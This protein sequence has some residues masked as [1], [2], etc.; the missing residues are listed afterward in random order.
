MIT[1]PKMFLAAIL[2]QGSIGSC[3]KRKIP[4]PANKPVVKPPPGPMPRKNQFP[5]AVLCQGPIGSCSKRKIPPP[6]NKPVVK[7]PSGPMPQKKG[8]M[9]RSAV[10]PVKT[11]PSQDDTNA[12]QEEE[13]IMETGSDTPRAPSDSF[14]SP[15]G[16]KPDSFMFEAL[17]EVDEWAK[18]RKEAPK[19]SKPVKRVAPKE[20]V[21]E[22]FSL[23]ARC[24]IARAA[25]REEAANGVTLGNVRLDLVRAIGSLADLGSDDFWKATKNQVSWEKVQDEKQHEFWRAFAEQIVDNKVFNKM[26]EENW[27]GKQVDDLKAFSDYLKS[28]KDIAKVKHM[29]TENINGYVESLLN[30]CPVEISWEWARR[31]LLATCRS[32]LDNDAR[33]ARQFK[34]LVELPFRQMLADKDYESRIKQAR[35]KERLLSIFETYIVQNQLASND[36]MYQ[37]MIKAASEI[38]DQY[39]NQKGRRQLISRLDKAEGAGCA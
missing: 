23:A 33:V 28:N 22:L 31:S 36:V 17:H 35:S 32:I 9:Q 10:Q 18:K 12:P 6:A 13:K 29:K 16:V 4:P 38:C 24:R 2:C 8:K 20:N 26:A 5:A 37:K 30:K 1:T 7:P 3:S 11:E 21:K 34:K 39:I 25:I 14:D 15:D 19:P 27:E